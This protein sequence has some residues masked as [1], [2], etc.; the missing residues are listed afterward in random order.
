MVRC[1]PDESAFEPIILSPQMC[2][3]RA[4]IVQIAK[5]KLPILVLG[6]T[7]SGKEVMAE[8][9]HRHGAHDRRP[10][11]KINCAGLTESVVESELFGHERGAFTGALQAHTGLFE[12]ADGGT[13]LLDEV[14][15][16]PP[17][18]QAKLLRV[19]ESGELMRVGSARSRRVSVR[20][21]AATH[22]DLPQLV[23]TGRFRQDLYF[24]LNGV[25]VTLAPLRERSEEVIPLA[26]H[27]IA[28]AA[29]RAE[30][31]AL[32][33]SAAAQDALLAHDWPGNVR[34]LRNVMERA[35]ALCESRLIDVELLGLDPASA[36]S[37]APPAVDGGGLRA[38]GPTSGIRAAVRDFERARIVAA[39]ART[40]GNQTAAAKLLGVSRR[41]LCN[42]LSAHEITRPRARSRA[43]SAPDSVRDDELL[44]GS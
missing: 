41:T 18:T 10:L 13:L 9:A 25:T 2:K 33:L 44:V 30:H 20:V 11:I 42:K 21:I 26:L 29:H 40:Q 38:V 39:L 6:E 32:G 23:A 24:R 8:L 36:P 27:F 31:T 4:L 16:L 5:T 34:E 1:L 14:G 3:A 12:Q 35:A 22:R 37:K 43:A 7:G 19:L 28:R 17:R 15:E